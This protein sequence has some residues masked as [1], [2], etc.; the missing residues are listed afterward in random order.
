MFEQQISRLKK[1]A[2]IL[3]K[4]HSRK[5]VRE[6]RSIQRIAAETNARQQGKTIAQTD[7]I[8]RLAAASIPDEGPENKEQYRTSQVRQDDHLVDGI[9]Q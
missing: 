7:E 5:G 9:Y 3:A 1:A 6:K 4:E 8:G 2:E